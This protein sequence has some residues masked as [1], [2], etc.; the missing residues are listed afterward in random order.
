MDGKSLKAPERVN[1]L[2]SEGIKLISTDCKKAIEKFSE[3]LKIEANFREHA[4][5][6]YCYIQLGEYDKG[7]ED[8]KKAFTLSKNNLPIKDMSVVYAQVGKELID[9]V[10]EGKGNQSTIDS[11]IKYFG[12]GLKVNR[13]NADIH[14]EVA[15]MSSRAGDYQKC[16]IAA[17]EAIEYQ[18]EHADAR[19]NRAGCYIGLQ[20]YKEAEADL[21][22][23]LKQ[24]KSEGALI[25]KAVLTDLRKD[26]A[27]TKAV[28]D[29][30]AKIKSSFN[31]N[32]NLKNCK[33]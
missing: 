16:L 21:D 20:K 1:A 26:C 32:P 28:R 18:P 14:S 23:S 22:I 13:K 6:G 5:R 25:M 30:L 10:N 27:A 19:A 17:S 7:I 11:A 4:N 3:A 8:Y 24:T 9:K 12:E 33:V 29:E 2:A 31:L 15:Y